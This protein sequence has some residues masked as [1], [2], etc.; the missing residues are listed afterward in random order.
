MPELTT[1]VIAALKRILKS[2]SKISSVQICLTYF[3]FRN[4]TPIFLLPTGNINSNLFHQPKALVLLFLQK[5]TIKYIQLFRTK[6]RL[7]NFFLSISRNIAI[8]N[9]IFSRFILYIKALYP[10]SRSSKTPLSSYK[11]GQIKISVPFIN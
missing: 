10:S 3:H 2:P 8:H 6:Y 1:S 4:S 7:F 11:K 9:T 5:N